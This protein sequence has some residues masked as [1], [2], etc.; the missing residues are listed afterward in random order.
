MEAGAKGGIHAGILLGS[1][2]QEPK[3]E[4]TVR[5]HRLPQERRPCLLLLDPVPKDNRVPNDHHLGGGGPRP[6][7][8]KAMSIRPR[9]PPSDRRFRVW[10][11][12]LWPG[13][14]DTLM[15]V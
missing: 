9:L 13:G 4:H 15:F 8:A 11:S 5:C 14:H 1:R 10:L 12:R 3:V 7:I 6:C 2:L